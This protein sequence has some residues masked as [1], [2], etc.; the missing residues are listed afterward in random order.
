MLLGMS[1]DDWPEM[2]DGARYTLILRQATII[3]C[4]Q[5]GQPRPKDV[6]VEEWDA[7]GTLLAEQASLE[8]EFSAPHEAVRTRLINALGEYNNHAHA[9]A[10]SAAPRPSQT[11]PPS[12]PHSGMSPP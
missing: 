10:H 1:P 3:R 11:H 8:A 5:E 2:D 6:S 9:R 12:T 7:V 4:H